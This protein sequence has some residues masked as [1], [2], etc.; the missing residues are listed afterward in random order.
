MSDTIPCDGCNGS[1]RAPLPIPLQ[2]T[3]DAVR[4]GHA[5]APAIY[6]ALNQGDIDPTAINRRLDRLLALGF[7]TREMGR[8]TAYIYTATPT[9]RKHHGRRK[10]GRSE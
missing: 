10:A 7:V 2:E 5:T 9:K 4:Q 6:R 3:L 1:G 8:K